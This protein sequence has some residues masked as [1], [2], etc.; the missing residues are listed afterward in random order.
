LSCVR[1]PGKSGSVFYYSADGRFMIKTITKSECHFL[2][3]VSCRALFLDSDVPSR[4][5]LCCFLVAL[6]LPPC[7]PG[8]MLTFF[9]CRFCPHIMSTSL[10]FLTHFSF[11]SWVCCRRKTYLS[12]AVLTCDVRSSSC[13]A[14]QRP[15]SVYC[16]DAECAL[17]PIL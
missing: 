1:S 3:D 13:Q 6:P 15:K 7:T 14:S 5:N 8:L 16:G 12:L 11:A 4:F 9:V 2:Q 17:Q 10:D